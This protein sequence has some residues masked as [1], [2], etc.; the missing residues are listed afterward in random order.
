[1]PDR[2]DGAGW[3][4]WY[5]DEAHGS[6]TWAADSADLYDWQVRGPVLEHRPHEGPNVSALDGRYWMIVDC[7]DGQDVFRSTDLDE[8][9]P[10]GRVLNGSGTRRDDQGVGHHA[11]VVAG[12]DAAWVFYFTHPQRDAVPAQGHGPGPRRSVVQP[13]RITADG[14]RL[15]LGRDT[16]AFHGLPRP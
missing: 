11:D 9:V 6:H 3:R 7:W 13:A 15:L 8:W 16:V 5:K 1:M 14:D 4:M 2:W 12:P 10:A